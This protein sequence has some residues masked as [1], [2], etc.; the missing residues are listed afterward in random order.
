MLTC[1]SSNRQNFHAN[2]F[3]CKG[4]MTCALLKWW[5]RDDVHT[6]TMAGTWWR[7]RSYNGGNVM[8]CALLQWRERDDVRAPTMVGTWWCAS[9]WNGGNV[10]MC[11]LLQLWER[12]DVHAPEMAGTGWRAHSYN[13]GKRKFREKQTN[14]L[15]SAHSPRDFLGN[16]HCLIYL[17]AT[18]QH[19]YIKTWKHVN[20]LQSYWKYKA[21]IKGSTNLGLARPC[22][23]RSTVGTPKRTNLV[24]SDCSMLENFWKAMFLITGGSWER[25]IQYWRGA[26][27]RFLCGVQLS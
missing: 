25:K 19:C 2:A 13:G 1:V 23:S 24:K 20:N 15:S 5:E 16:L 10:M 17:L 7:A 9:S 14:K 18:L 22:A 11:A 8:M 12:D 3:A 26:L 27:K 6:P 21:V 4:V